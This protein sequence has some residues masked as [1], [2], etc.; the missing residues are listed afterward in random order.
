MIAPPYWLNDVAAAMAYAEG[1]SFAALATEAQDRYRTLALAAF[2]TWEGGEPA[3]WPM[4]PD[5][6]T[7]RQ[8]DDLRTR[9]AAAETLLEHVGRVLDVDLEDQNACKLVADRLERERAEGEKDATIPSRANTAQRKA[10]RLLLERRVTVDAVNP[11]DHPTLPGYVL[12]SCRGD[13]GDYVLGYD[14]RRQQWRC[15]CPEL[16]GECSHLIALRMIVSLDRRD[17]RQEGQA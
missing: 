7:E 1:E 15:T 11:A 10:M 8:L 16:R 14:P 4:E 6:E 13:E 9:L 5:P 17:R 2:E 12:A 3:G